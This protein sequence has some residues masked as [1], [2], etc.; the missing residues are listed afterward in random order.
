MNEIS[1]PQ[2][3]SFVL[4]T[5]RNSSFNAYVVGGFLRDAIMGRVPMDFDVASSAKPE[6]VMALFEKTLDIGIKHGTITV[7]YNNCK[8]EVTTFRIDGPYKDSRHPEEVFFTEDIVADLSRRDFTINSI[9]YNPQ[10]GIIDPFNGMDD[11][12]NKVVRCVGEPNL[13]FKEDALRIL[14][15]IRFSTCLSFDINKETYEALCLNIKD[16]ANISSERIREEFNKILISNRPSKGIKILNNTGFFKVFTCFSSLQFE[17]CE[18][19]ID[20]TEAI[21]SLRLS[22]L[23]FSLAEDNCLNLP[24]VKAILKYLKYD[25]KTLLE[26]TSILS[27]SNEIPKL[28]DKLSFKKLLNRYDFNVVSLS[29]KLC[30]GYGKAYGDKNLLKTVELLEDYLIEIKSLKE[31]IYL[32]DLAITGEDLLKLGYIKGISL[33]LE[34]KRLLALSL[35][36]PQINKKE[37]LLELAKEQRIDLPK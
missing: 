19:L 24:K 7:I 15:C 30:Y 32:C 12:K 25:N 33:G 17:N 3:V 37:I 29:L 13:R 36:N 21:L 28:S 16:L 18:A 34:L 1:L 20:F 4:N 22:S 5:L 31:P 26:V 2:E 9:A 35:E 14:R 23:F 6:E 10:E 27:I 11:I 8:I